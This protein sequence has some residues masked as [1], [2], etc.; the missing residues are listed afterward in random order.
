M[1]GGVEQLQDRPG[2]DTG[3]GG[4]EGLEEVQC[5][6]EGGDGGDRGDS[7]KSGY[8]LLHVLYSFFSTDNLCIPGEGR[9]Q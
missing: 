6:V 2:E 3:G 9:W 5:G 1:E 4:G 8:Q 7:V